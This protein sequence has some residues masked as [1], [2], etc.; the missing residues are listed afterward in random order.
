MKRSD[1]NFVVDGLAF[2]MF[3]FLITTGAIMEFLLPAGSG[4]SLTLWGFDRH[5][6]GDIHF[7][8]SIAFLSLLAL[9]LYLH[10]K[11][12]FYVARGRTSRTSN[13]R[14]WGVALGTVVV[15][16]GALAILTAPV[17]EAEGAEGGRNRRF[18]NTQE[19]D[20]S[21]LSREADHEDSLIGGSNRIRGSMR[22]SDLAELGIS[23][24]HL[25]NEL[26][27]PSDVS[28]D[29]TLGRMSREY[30]FTME[31]VREVVESYLKRN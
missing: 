5:E 23:I 30:G 24:D 17:V 18:A 14:A 8:I 26:E 22:L 6:W 1:L 11:W 12:I 4:H 29:E 15:V 16:V 7:W 2:A 9:H 25:K 10:W 21:H 3:V 28:I 20:E 31:F 13:R 27:L 19:P